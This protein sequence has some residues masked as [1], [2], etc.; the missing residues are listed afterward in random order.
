M[1]GALLVARCHYPE[2]DE[3]KVRV[4]ID[5][6]V[7]NVWVNL[8]AG[9]TADQEVR[10]LN[11]ILFTEMGFSGNK[12]PEP[13]PDLAYLNSVIDTRHG[14]SLGLGIVYLIVAHALNLNIYGINLPY[15]FILCY[16]DRW[17]TKEELDQRTAEGAVKFYINPLLEGVPFSRIEITRYLDK[18]QIHP[19][20]KYFAPCDNLTIIRTL[21][22]NQISCYEEKG[23]TDRL[24]KLRVLYDLCS[25]DELPF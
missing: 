13:E 23:D 2:L 12:Q 16:T 4:I 14:N 10:V 7:K 6:I 20:S 15:H 21:I 8:T 19:E 18:S 25:G 5:G 24:N 22:F 3:H 9:M 1:E 11:R 17:L